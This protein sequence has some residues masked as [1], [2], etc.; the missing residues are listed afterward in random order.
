MTV[1]VTGSAARW[2]G[3]PRA[4]TD[5]AIAGDRIPVEHAFYDLSVNYEPI[6]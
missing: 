3:Q 5:L 4:N 6:N 2:F 1:T